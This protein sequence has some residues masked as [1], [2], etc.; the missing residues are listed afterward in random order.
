M[1]NCA[2]HPPLDKDHITDGSGAGGGGGVEGAAEDGAE[3]KQVWRRCGAGQSQLLWRNSL[4]R[5]REMRP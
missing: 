1:T 5:H 4:M 2:Y 3:A